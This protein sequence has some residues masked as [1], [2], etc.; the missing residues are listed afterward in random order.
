MRLYQKVMHETHDWHEFS[1][2]L[3][4]WHTLGILR[5]VGHE[6]SGMTIYDLSR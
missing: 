1:N 3:D 4:N 2:A 5:V 6:Q